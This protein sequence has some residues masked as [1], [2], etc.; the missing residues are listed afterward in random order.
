LNS[1]LSST[2][3]PT[4]KY[5]LRNEAVAWQNLSPEA[6]L[7]QLE[8]EEVHVANPTAATLIDALQKGATVE[9]L[10]ARMTSDYEVSAAQAAADVEAFLKAALDAGLL[11]EEPAPT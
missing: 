6:V 9:E 5:R 2:L 1:S 10:V 4:S 3:S 8:R 7:V 11:S